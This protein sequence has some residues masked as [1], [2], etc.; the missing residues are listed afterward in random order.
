[1]KNENDKDGESDEED[2][3]ADLDDED[4][5]EEIGISGHIYSLVTDGTYVAVHSFEE[6][7]ELFF[8]C[9]VIRKNIAPC[10]IRDNR[11]HAICK[12]DEYFEVVYLEK[13]CM[14]RRM[15]FY[16]KL[17]DIVY[18]RPE[19][20]FCPAIAFNESDLSMTLAEYQFVADCAR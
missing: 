20:V 11:K 1:M 8:L 9:Y 13:Q 14:K 5:I 12:G 2:E 19:E 10:N 6:S 17:N 16:K 15:V 18:L 3:L 7:M 4:E